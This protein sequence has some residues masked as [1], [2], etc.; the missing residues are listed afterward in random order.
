M[1]HEWTMW[2]YRDGHWDGPTSKPPKAR[3]GDK[4]VIRRGKEDLVT[5]VVD[6][7]GLIEISSLGMGYREQ[8]GDRQIFIREGPKRR[9]DDVR[10][11]A[12]ESK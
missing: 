7:Q 2:V 6:E 3:A 8:E 12:G 1:K 10:K 4:F 11:A 5:W 9:D